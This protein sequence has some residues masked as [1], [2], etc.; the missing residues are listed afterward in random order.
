M[1]V[2][3]NAREG[4]DM[5]KGFVPILMNALKELIIAGKTRT[6]GQLINFCGEKLLSLII[7]LIIYKCF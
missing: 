2:S 1:N 7:L 6:A 5:R 4:F 3:K